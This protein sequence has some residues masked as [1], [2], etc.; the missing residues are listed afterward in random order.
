MH[1]MTDRYP[2]TRGLDAVVGDLRTLLARVPRQHSVAGRDGARRS[3][4][5]TD[6]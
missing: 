2:L 4:A 6:L 3:G 1:L 5:G